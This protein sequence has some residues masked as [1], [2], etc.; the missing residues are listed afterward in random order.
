MD[1]TSG[2]YAPNG[3]HNVGSYVPNGDLK[4]DFYSP[5]VDRKGDLPTPNGEH[6]G[7]LHGP[8]GDNGELGKT[9]TE[10]P[11]GVV[12]QTYQDRESKHHGSNAETTDST[13]GSYVPNRYHNADF[14]HQKII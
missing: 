13:T 5:N 6:N 14:M 2:S 8:N 7:D 1:S 12:T 10:N 4:G 11:T 3:D 9:F